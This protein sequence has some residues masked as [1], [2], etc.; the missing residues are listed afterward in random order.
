MAP[1]LVR[2]A[3]GA[4]TS[5]FSGNYNDLTNKPTIP[6]AQIQSDWAQTVT[7]SLDYIKNKPSL[8]T[9]ATSGSYNDL[10]DKPTIPTPVTYTAEAGITIT[11][12]NV[13]KH[14][15]TS[16]T[17]Q[18]TQGFYPVKI[19][20]Y[21]HIT[22]VGSRT[23]SFTPA[24][25]AH[26]AITNAGSITAGASNANIIATPASVTHFVVT[27]SSN[28]IKKCL[29]TVALR[30]MGGVV[31][32]N[33]VTPDSNGNVAITIPTVGSGILTIQRNGVSAGTFGANDS[34]AKTINITVPTDYISVY[35]GEMDEDAGITFVSQADDMNATMYS[36][37]IQF[38]NFDNTKN[39]WVNFP[40]IEDGTTKTFATGLTASVSV[41]SGRNTL[42]IS[43]K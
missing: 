2:S 27:N 18:T 4:G 14:S 25:H 34:S 3:I 1:T 29:P 23:T 6:A 9:V 5:N 32:V 10:S 36:T 22:A 41:T 15:N 19:D 43:T 42:V 17:A 30:A 37:G 26:G 8:A 31:S 12:A 35:G 39:M 24:S 16:I 13:I 40:A 33:S 11:S 21:G 7:T 38:N 28:T 20:A